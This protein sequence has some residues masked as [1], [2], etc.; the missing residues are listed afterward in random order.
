VF[1]GIEAMQQFDLRMILLRAVPLVVLS[2][3]LAYSIW[4]FK[5]N[6]IFKYWSLQ[7]YNIGLQ[8]PFPIHIL[9]YG[10]I[11]VLAFWRI[12]QYKSNPLSPSAN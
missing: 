8:A 5:F 2:P 12:S 9:A 6:Q 1:I 7:G 10:I 11:G 4:I 3:A